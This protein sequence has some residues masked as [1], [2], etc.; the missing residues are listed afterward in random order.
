[1]EWLFL[2][3]AVFGGT[4]MVCQFALTLLGISDIDD[5]D[6]PD[7]P[8][9]ADVSAFDGH[10]DAADGHA[11]GHDGHHHGTNWLFGVISFRTVVAALAFFGLSGMAARSAGLR[12]EWVPLVIALAAGWTAMYAVHWLMRTLFRMRSEG[13]ARIE[14]SVGKVGAVYLRVP[15]SRAGTGKITLNLQNRTME[16]LAVTAAEAIPTGANIV[17]VGVVGPDT[18]EVELA[19]EHA[20]A[21]ALAPPAAPA[22]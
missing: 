6:L 21:G 2:I 1:M 11:A 15:A 20:H 7:A 8:A 16:Y 13:T 19:P 17:V 12:P 22:D 14:Y 18:V 5:L 9:D 4:I 10:V 3:C